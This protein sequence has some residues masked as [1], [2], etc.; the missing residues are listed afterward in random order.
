MTRACGS[1]PGSRR[2]IRRPEESRERHRHRSLPPGALRTER[3]DRLQAPPGLLP[4]GPALGGRGGV[5]GPRRPVDAVW[6]CTAR[7]SSTA[8]QRA[9]GPSASTTW[10]PLKKSH[11][12]LIYQDFLSLPPRISPCVPISPP[13]TDVRVRRALSHAID[14]QAIIEAVE[15]RGEP[16]A[17]VPRGLV[18]WSLPVDQLGEGAKYYQYDPQ[19][20]RRLLAEAGVSQGLENAA[21]RYE[22]LWPRPHR[23]RAVGAALPQRR[24]HRGGV[25]APGVWR[26][27]RDDQRRASSRVWRWGRFPLAG[28]RIACCMA[29][30]SPDQPRNTRPRQRPHSSRRCS[31]SNGGRQDLAARKQRIFDIQRY[32]AE[33]QYYVYLYCGMLTGSCQ[34][35][36]KNY[37]PNSPPGPRQCRRRAVAGPL[38]AGRTEAYTVTHAGAWPVMGGPL[39]CKD[40]DRRAGGWP[41]GRA[42]YTSSP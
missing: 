1:L 19:E 30:M 9:G 38:G 21:P 39:S 11:P 26:V 7:G 10:H 14:R 4:Q 5:A 18:E 42:S 22:W 13:S 8:A 23:C 2:A 29:R 15:L 3:E 28:S 27:Y 41:G 36:V 25:E 16:T 17:A 33:Q 35:Y 37:A 31:R 34:P 24:R 12:H 40:G 20:A 6:P 32:A